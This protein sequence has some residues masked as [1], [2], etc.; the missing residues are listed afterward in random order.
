MP[1]TPSGENGHTANPVGQML[2]LVLLI[3]AQ[4]EAMAEIVAHQVWEVGRADCTTTWRGQSPLF[5]TWR[6]AS[7]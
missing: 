1:G 5:M 4:E 6:E 3:E 7:G 2:L